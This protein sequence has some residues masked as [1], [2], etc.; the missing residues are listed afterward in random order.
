MHACDF[1]IKNPSLNRME[2]L[3]FEYKFLYVQNVLHMKEYLWKFNTGDVFL[4]LDFAFCSVKFV[5]VKIPKW[6]VRVVPA[7]VERYSFS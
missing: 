6:S 4:H 2:H 3:L 5:H 7:L 1:C